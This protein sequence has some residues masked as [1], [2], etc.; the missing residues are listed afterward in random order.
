MSTQN[1]QY[2]NIPGTS[3]QLIIDDILVLP[4]AFGLPIGLLFGLVY[5]IGLQWTCGIV[6]TAVLWRIINGIS[7]V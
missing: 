5:L 2:F 4:L 7:I 6:F 1:R 3:R